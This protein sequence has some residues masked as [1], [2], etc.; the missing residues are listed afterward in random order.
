MGK[1]GN[2]E[3]GKTKYTIKQHYITTSYVDVHGNKCEDTR[4]SMWYILNL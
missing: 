2:K 3:K 1:E 4:L